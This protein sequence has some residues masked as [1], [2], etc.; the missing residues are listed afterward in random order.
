MDYSLKFSRDPWYDLRYIGVFLSLRDI[1][2]VWVCLDVNVAFGQSM[3][4]SAG[5]SGG[6]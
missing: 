2:R 6:S 5:F 1:G 4:M 3:S